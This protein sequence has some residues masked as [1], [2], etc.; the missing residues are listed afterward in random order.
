MNSNVQFDLMTSVAKISAAT[1]QTP[2]SEVIANARA[3]GARGSVVTGLRLPASPFAIDD[4]DTPAFA[5]AAARFG[6]SDYGYVVT[7]NADHLIRLHEDV[8]FRALYATATYVLLDSRF[9]AHILRITRGMRLP[10]CTGSDLTSKLFAGVISAYDALV[11]VGGSPAQAAQLARQY[12]LRRLAHFNPP[13]GFIHDPAA[14]EDCLRFVEA[15]SPF[16][17]CLLALG[18]PQQEIVAQRLQ[19]RGIARGLALCVGASIDFMTGTE[20][21]APRV[22]QVCG[23]E[24]L[25]RLARSPARLATR[26]L[27]RGPRVFGLL[28]RTDVVLRPAL[29]RV[30]VQ[31]IASTEIAR[32]PVTAKPVPRL[33]RAVAVPGRR[34]ERE[35]PSASTAG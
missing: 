6:Q 16:R 22:L 8:S 32:R 15:H 5:D 2:V 28:R 11:L 14:V 29:A 21:R 10:V 3:G 35:A 24:W 31:A 12:G 18:S 13:M 17:F 9:L 26:Y 33:V 23:L 19:E 7:P 25:Y 34:A 27:V 4:F 30:A 1:P 20:R